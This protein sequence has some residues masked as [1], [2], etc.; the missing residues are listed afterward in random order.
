MI[1]SCNSDTPQD[2]RTIFLTLA[3][4]AGNTLSTTFPPLW[5]RVM[6]VDLPKAR[7]L[8]GATTSN[9]WW[10][11]SCLNRQLRW[12]SGFSTSWVLTEAFKGDSQLRPNCLLT[13]SYCFP[14]LPLELIQRT[15]SNKF[16]STNL[17]L[18]LCISRNLISDMR[19]SNSK[20]HPMQYQENGHCTSVG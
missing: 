19:W 16:L 15:A 3:S 12:L 18:K 5:L 7:F 9:A 13:H 1:T 17:C 4:T 2:W 11:L 8:F 6:E 20:W 14:S 10:M